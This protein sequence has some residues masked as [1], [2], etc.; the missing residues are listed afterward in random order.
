MT[1]LC[2]ATIDMCGLP[3]DAKNLPLI[4]IHAHVSK[5]TRSSELF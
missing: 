5:R 1:H 4:M 2:A 3:I